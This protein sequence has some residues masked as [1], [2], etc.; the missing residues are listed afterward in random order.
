MKEFVGADCFIV[1]E[2]SQLDGGVG[3]IA[4]IGMIITKGEK[5][6]EQ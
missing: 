4:D 3:D 6:D 5:Q 1:N 2:L